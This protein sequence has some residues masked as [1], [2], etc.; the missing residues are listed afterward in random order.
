MIIQSSK[1][2][3]P[4]VMEE[5]T[6]PEFIAGH[7]RRIAAWEKNLSW[8]NA[9]VDEVYA[10]HKGK[11]ICVAGQELFAADTPQEAR[12]LAKA[13]HPNDEEIYSRYIPRNNQPRI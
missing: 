13:A 7:R 9:H 3:P 10:K 12:A 8:M 2:L 11:C 1:P 6:D 4:I 5:I